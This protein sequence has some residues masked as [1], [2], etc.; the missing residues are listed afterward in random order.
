MKKTVV[1][2]LCLLL[3]CATAVISGG[4]S[5]DPLGVAVSPQTLLLGASQGGHVVVHTDG[6]PFGAVVG[7]SVTLNGVAARSV[8]ADTCGDL[9]ANFDEAAIKAIVAVPSARLTLAGL[10][11]DGTAFSGSDTVR[12]VQK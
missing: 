2:S 9:V 12:V 4:R 1:I 7:S 11:V 8:S 5:T 10:K 3:A 6:L